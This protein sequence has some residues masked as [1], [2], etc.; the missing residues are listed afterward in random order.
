MKSKVEDA[1][2]EDIAEAGMVDALA[3][4]ASDEGVALK[5]HSVNEQLIVDVLLERHGG[6]YDADFEAAA[7]L[8][9]P[10]T[11][12]DVVEGTAE[13][14]LSLRI[15]ADTVEIEAAVEWEALIFEV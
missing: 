8:T 12:A 7:E 15:E 9:A 5:E 10:L 14:S 2:A 4:E 11:L 1:F 13:G 3:T 6:T